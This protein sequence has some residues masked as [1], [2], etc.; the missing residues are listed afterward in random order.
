MIGTALATPIRMYTHFINQLARSINPQIV[1]ATRQ[2]S[3]FDLP[4]DPRVS[5]VDPDHSAVL[6][7]IRNNAELIGKQMAQMGH[8]IKRTGKNISSVGINLLE[9]SKKATETLSKAPS[10]LPP[11]PE[12]TVPIGFKPS[13]NELLKL[14]S[15]VPVVSSET[16][17]LIPETF[18]IS[19]AA[20]ELVSLNKSENLQPIAEVITKVP[21][22]LPPTSSDLKIVETVSPALQPV[23]VSEVLPVTP[24]LN[25]VNEEVSSQEIITEPSVPAAA[26][27][28][29]VT[30]MEMLAPVSSSSPVSVE[31]LNATSVLLSNMTALNISNAPATAETI[32]TEVTQA[33]ATESSLFSEMKTLGS[34][35]VKA[36]LQ[37]V[38]E[39]DT[40]AAASTDAQNDKVSLVDTLVPAVNLQLKF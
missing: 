15:S 28:V 34:N 21:F 31:T 18:E 19:S 20:N 23:V 32:L 36:E 29:V 12:E 26:A 27:A 10:R 17:T 9:F 1:P 2:T 30:T 33:E 5:H 37:S 13:V 8:E 6:L 14:N 22:S 24:V 11:A 35:F 25:I 40:A 3:L 16:A 38:A 4:I 39:P 7:A